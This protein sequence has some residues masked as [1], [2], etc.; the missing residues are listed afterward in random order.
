MLATMSSVPAYWPREPTE[1][2]VRALAVEVFHERVGCVGLEGDAIIAVNYVAIGYGN[3]AAAVYVSRLE[4]W[5]AGGC[6]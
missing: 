3:V 5:S 1:N 6:E 4:G 2:A